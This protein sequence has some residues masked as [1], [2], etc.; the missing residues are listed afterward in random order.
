MIV[1][2]NL[3]HFDGSKYR[4]FTYCVMPNHVH[5]VFMPLINASLER[6]LHSWKSFT[7]NR[8][9]DMLG[10]QGRLWQPERY[11]RLIRDENE[12]WRIVGYVVE[13]PIKAGLE[14]WE[15]VWC[16]EDIGEMNC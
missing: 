7:S 9:N 8:I 3:E 14:N 16:F 5:V 1:I 4:L 6:I 2:E 12:F 10:L 13:N 15:W 11:D